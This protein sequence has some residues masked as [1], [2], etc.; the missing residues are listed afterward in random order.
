[1]GADNENKQMSAKMGSTTGTYWAETKHVH[2]H[3][4]HAEHASN[5]LVPTTS[6]ARGPPMVPMAIPHKTGLT[7][8]PSRWAFTGWTGDTG[9]AANVKWVT[10]LPCMHHL[11][12]I[13]GDPRE[14][15]T[16]T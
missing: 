2:R 14:Q 12:N 1:M 13:N 9:V 6:T 3:D 5:P 11:L 16:K 4:K 7:F 15:N 8:P 10:Q